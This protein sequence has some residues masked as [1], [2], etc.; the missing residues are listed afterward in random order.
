[1]TSGHRLL[2]N[3]WSRYT[4]LTEHYNGELLSRTFIEGEHLTCA[5]LIVF[6]KLH[7]VII[8]LEVA[9]KLEARNICRWFNHIQ[10][11]PQLTE[12]ID[13]LGKERL[14]FPVTI[15]KK[16]LKAAEKK[17]K[18]AAAVD[19]PRNPKVAAK[20]AGEAAD[21]DAK[22]A[23]AEGAGK[24]SQQK[25]AKKGKDAGKEAEKAEEGAVKQA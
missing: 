8:D 22:Q 7:S 4:Q 11:L 2:L 10:H 16:D 9:S 3:S 12:V 23:P 25:Q 19:N 24:K 17:A 20:L 15:S 5:D 13:Q 6:C 21:G 14:I 18:K 1:M